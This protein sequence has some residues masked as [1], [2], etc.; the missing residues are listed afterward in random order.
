MTT[1][2]KTLLRHRLEESAA[3]CGFIAC[4]MAPAAP[5][6]AWRQE[7]VRRWMEAGRAA[8]M[9]YLHRHFALRC[10]PQ[11]VE[12]SAL[13]VVSVALP[14]D[15]QPS[16]AP[17]ALRLSRYALG[18]DYHEVVKE[19][20]RRMVRLLGYD[21]SHCGRIC[22]DTAPVDERYWA[23]R[24]GVG[25][26]LRS[27]LISVRGHGT[28]VVL[29]EWLA[30]L[31]MDP[32]EAAADAVPSVLPAEG[33]LT[34][35]RCVAACP[36][37]AL[38]GEGLDARR[39]LSYLTIEHRGPLPDHDEH[40][41]ARRAALASCFYGCDRCAEVCP[42]NTHPLP[43]EAIPP[44]LRPRP[45]LLNRKAEEWQAMTV[46]TYRELFRRSAV[47][48]AKLEGLMRNL[49]EGCEAT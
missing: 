4:G 39:C 10:N 6:A 42:H 16:F 34:C 26:W 28:C 21:P 36:G 17:D 5:L 3:Q 13:T 15:M 2:P 47:K 20:L 22:C 27:G 48:R 35:G 25:Q 32:A 46:E 18:D 12:P 8:E 31:P 23:W 43:A 11:L 1:P 37:G 24:T 33:C 14:Y 19:R 30:P 45:A 9:D 38:D 40:T 44:E 7:A 49:A 41:P 29:G